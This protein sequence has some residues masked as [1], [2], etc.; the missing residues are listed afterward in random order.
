M[1]KKKLALNNQQVLYL[2]RWVNKEHFRTFVYNEKGQRLANSYDEFEELIGSGL[3]FAEKPM[4]SKKPKKALKVV[5]GEQGVT[6]DGDTSSNS[7]TVC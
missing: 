4:V 2:G 1:N 3:W 6:G 7:E 5:P